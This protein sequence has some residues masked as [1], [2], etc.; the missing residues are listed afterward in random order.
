ME[1]SSQ[2]RRV[3]FA[4]SHLS[5]GGSSKGIFKLVSLLKSRKKGE[6]K[7][8]NSFGLGRSVLAGNMYAGKNLLKEPPYLFQVAGSDKEQWIYRTYLPVRGRKKL[9]LWV[10]RN[11]TGDNY[12][13]PLLK[14]FQL[15]IQKEKATPIKSFDDINAFFKK[16]RFSAKVLFNIKN[17]VIVLE[18]PIYHINLK[19]ETKMWQVETGPI[20]FPM[21]EKDGSSLHYMPGFVHF[22]SFKKLDI[23]Y[24]YPYGVRSI[25]LFNKGIL[26]GF[27]CSIKLF[28]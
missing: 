8:S 2:I 26:A 28:S 23:F 10:K 4:N 1:Y 15:N 5:W 9:P 12:G 14:E 7:L 6:G 27:P 18:F 17:D 19:N 13:K 25:N 3:D 22:N 24:D 16:N 11:K 20:L 21:V